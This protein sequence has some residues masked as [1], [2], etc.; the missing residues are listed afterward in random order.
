MTDRRARVRLEVVGVLWGALLPKEAVRVI[1]ISTGGALVTSPVPVET[2]S[3]QSLKV[4]INGR[5]LT[6]ESRIRHSR[7]LAPAQGKSVQYL[8]GMEFLSPPAAIETAL[9]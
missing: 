3:I 8:I 4:S 6:L 9:G 1:D 2:H 5:E 7:C